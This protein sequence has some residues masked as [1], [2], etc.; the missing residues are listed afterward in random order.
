[1]SGRS[2]LSGRAAEQN[3]IITGT[4]TGGPYTLNADVIQVETW[5]VPYF[6]L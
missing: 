5:L 3:I 6:L 2:R 1:M 4:L